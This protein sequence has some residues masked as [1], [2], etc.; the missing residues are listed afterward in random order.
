MA[1]RTSPL[2]RIKAVTIVGLGNVGWPLFQA[3]V[4]SGKYQVFGYDIDGERIQRLQKTLSPLTRKKHRL[5]TEPAE[6]LPH[7][8]YIV[9]C[10]PTSVTS[11]NKPNFGPVLA[12]VKTV[13]AHLLKKTTII[14]ESTVSPGT[15][16][17]RILPLLKQ[18]GLVASKDFFLAHCPE[19]I[20]PGDKKWNVRNIPRNVGGLTQKD[21]R[22]AARFYRSILR[23]PV[24]VMSSIQEVEST[25]MLENIFRDVNI[26]LINEFAMA[27]DRLG[28]DTLNVI[29]GASSKPFSFLPHY[30]GC[31]VGGDCIATDPYYFLDTLKQHGGTARLI[32]SSRQLNASMPRYLLKK[33]KTLLKNNPKLKK[34]PRLLVLGVAYKPEIADTRMSPALDVIKLLKKEGYRL[35]VYDPYVPQLSTVK[36]L[37]T[38]VAKAEGVILCTAHPQFLKALS[39]SRKLSNLPAFIVDGRNCLDKEGLLKKGIAYTGIGR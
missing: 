35:D 10:V 19:R 8:Q 32:A 6:C 21:A 4:R 18:S 15:C 25:K 3:V 33:L 16:E 30:P 28:I 12:A 11:T 38:A 23:A 5:T 26:A 39:P 24:H 27:F 37:N 34:N 17:T 2:P 9:I 22:S 13:S 7:S 29:K 14:I 31:G 20:N 1:G 36:D